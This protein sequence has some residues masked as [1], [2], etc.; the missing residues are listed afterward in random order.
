MSMTARIR[1]L[2]RRGVRKIQNRDDFDWPSYTEIYSEAL[3][4]H[5][6]AF[7]LILAESDYA[8]ENGRLQVSAGLPPLHPNHRLIYET[9]CRLNP[10]SVLEIGF[11]GGYHLINLGLLLPQAEIYGC[12]LL[13]SQ[14]QL[15]VSRY[16]S[17]PAR[18]NL[19][20]HD[21]TM[22][23]P[24][25]EADLVFTQTVVMHIQKDQRHLAALR[26]MFRVSRKYIVLMENWLSHNF[27]ADL[28]KLSREPGFPWQA[29]HMYLVDDMEQQILAILS[30]EEI[31]GLEPFTRNEQ[32]LKYL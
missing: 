15:A 20:V 17:L 14:L 28:T 22:E 1:R 21:I 10:G 23:P 30:N 19:M 7:T 13:E 11:G 29:L 9:A 12:D 2:L 25:I 24:P 18:A 32:L 3:N 5:C 16:P 4:E 31:E 6:K 8:I 26:N 27:F